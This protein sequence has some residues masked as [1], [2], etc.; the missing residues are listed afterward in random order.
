MENNNWIWLIALGA[1]VYFWQRSRSSQ[2]TGSSA[3]VAPV[4]S[5]NNLAVQTPV[6]AIA[7]PSGQVSQTVAQVQAP[8]S[9]IP[10]P[11]VTD[12]TTHVVVAQPP[13]ISQQSTINEA[14]NI[15]SAWSP[16]ITNQ[17]NV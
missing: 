2:S 6:V 7:A 5:A 1:G 12:T 16:N 3:S 11:V 4:V 9:K 15:V 8:V 10:I 13:V 14:G 17:Y